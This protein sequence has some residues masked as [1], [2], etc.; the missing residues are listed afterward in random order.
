MPPD[1]NPPDRAA[2]LADEL[3]LVRRS[4][5]LPEVALHASLHHLEAS[6]DGP[7]LVLT[8]AERRAL[9]RAAAEDYQDIIRRDLNPDNRD[10]RRF[11]GLARALVNWR[12]FV[13][14]RERHGPADD[15]EFQNFRAEAGRALIAYLEQECAETAAGLRAPSVNCP[16]SDVR[17][18]AEALGA[19]ED[20][21][22]S[23]EDL[24]DIKPEF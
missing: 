12:R 3:L 20:L 13:R 19:R 23:W 22:D 24:C 2:L 14:F 7:G 8:P 11:R 5:E 6:P 9:T 1:P 16:A 10:E 21:P 15:A 4:G 18:L 17:A